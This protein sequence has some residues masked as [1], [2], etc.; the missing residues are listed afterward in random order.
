MIF[1]YV[2]KNK[3]PVK[4]IEYVKQKN[5]DIKIKEL[6]IVTR[7]ILKMYGIDN[8]PALVNW[9][10]KKTKLAVGK[11]EIIYYLTYSK[12]SRL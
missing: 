10:I 6:D 1:L 3:I 7:D 5:F 4:V 11:D 8:F 12:D 2:E 9:S